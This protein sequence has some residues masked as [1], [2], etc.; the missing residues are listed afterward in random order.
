MLARYC[1]HARYQEKQK[2]NFARLD[3]LALE[4]RFLARRAEQSV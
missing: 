1:E 2:I 3:I 4:F